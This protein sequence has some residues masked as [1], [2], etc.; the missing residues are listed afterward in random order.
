MIN[1]TISKPKI[2]IRAVKL[3][4]F[5]LIISFP[6]MGSDCGKNIV[7]GSP[8]DL[9]G[10]WQLV[11][12]TGYLQDVCTGEVVNYFSNGT[13]TLQCPGEQMITRNYTVSNDVLTYQPSGL[14]YNITS[15]T[16]TNLV[17][18]GVN[19]GRTLTYNRLP[20]DYILRNDGNSKSTNSS[21][22]PK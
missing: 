4:T 17:L 16:T 22:K 2:Q 7:G 1:F 13:V 9:V 21:E 11:F 18:S 20:D 10:K 14:Q 8:G 5:A 19:V 12:M 3:L 6:L 15:L